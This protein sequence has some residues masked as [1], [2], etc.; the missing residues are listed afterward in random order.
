M[1]SFHVLIKVRHKD[2]ENISSISNV[3]AQTECNNPDLSLKKDTIIVACYVPEYSDEEPQLGKIVNVQNDRSFEVEWM[4]GT[5]SEPLRIWRERKGQD[6][7]TWK[8]TI[9]KESI[10]FPIIC[11]PNQAEY[12]QI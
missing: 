8:E 10:L 11:Y 3:S 9:A 1:V 5:Y 2:K 7:I 12:L 4:V 6:Y